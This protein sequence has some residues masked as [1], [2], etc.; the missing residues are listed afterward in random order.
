[1]V[2]LILSIIG[3]VAAGSLVAYAVVLTIKWLKNKIAEK[4]AQKNA[5]KVAVID[6]GTLINECENKISL[7]ELN[8]LNNLA[9]EGYTHMI[10][11]VNNSGKVEDV[12]VI[13]D[14]SD[15]IDREVKEL[16]N[17]THEGMIIVEG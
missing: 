4:L 10:A 1:M 16:I 2:G 13:E 8:N 15:T 9:N 17:R 5:K 3:L 12:E 14:T 7:D 11:T 6:V